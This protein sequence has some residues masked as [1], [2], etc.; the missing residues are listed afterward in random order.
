[1]YQRR[2]GKT[3]VGAVALAGLWGAWAAG[4]SD[5]IDVP[6]RVDHFFDDARGVLFVSTQAGNI[7]RWD[8]A[9]GALL[10]PYAVGESLRGMDVTPDGGTIY[11]ADYVVGEAGGRIRVVD[12]DTGSSTEIGYT[13]AFGEG[14]AWDVVIGMQ[15]TGFVTTQFEG[16]GWVPLRALDTA[17]NQLTVVAGPTSGDVRQRTKLSRSADRGLVLMAESNTSAGPV[18]TYD[19]GSDQYQASLN[20]QIS[21]SNLAAAVNPDGSV[22][23]LENYVPRAIDL[24]DADLQFLR[25]L[26]VTAAGVLFDPANPRFFYADESS[27]ELV[28]LSTNTWEELARW[29]IGEPYSGGPWWEFRRVMSAT[30]D[31][32]TVFLSTSSGVRA[33]STTPLPRDTDSDDDGVFDDIDNCVLRANPAQ[34]DAD[35]DGLGNL[36]DGD[37]NGDWIVNVTDLGL[38]KEAFFTSDP[39]IDLNSDGVV[40]V[41]DLGIL[42]TLAFQ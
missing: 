12:V 32:T 13:L 15:G 34:V 23:A 39:V 26:L 7:E 1:M 4:A 27:D 3:L 33:I 20:T 40:N 36:C 2:I 11:A 6:D 28:A 14:G 37:F 16:S 41:I 18:R 22:V 24:Y 19:F 35:G 38:M 31:G 21:R 5:V 9:S 25:R 17:S 29:P 10:A 42:R 8:A 30:G